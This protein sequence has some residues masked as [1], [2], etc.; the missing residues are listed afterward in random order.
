LE[1]A[2][3]VRI[4]PGQL[5]VPMIR[6]S[7]RSGFRPGACRLLLLF[8]A[9]PLLVP[10]R[11][12]VAQ[13]RPGSVSGAARLPQDST[14]LLKVGRDA[15]R[16]FENLHR[17]RL[18][19]TRDDGGGSCDERL[20]RICL[21]WTGGMAWAP[22][23]EDPV[24]VAARNELLETLAGIAREIPGDRW[25]LG[26]R[27]RYLGDVG[28]WEEALSIADDC[29]GG[30]P[31]WCPAL[32]GYLL[33]RSG[34]AHEAAEAFHLALERMGGRQAAKWWDPSV[35]LEYPAARWIR[36]PDGVSAAQ[37]LERF[38]RFADPLFLTPGNERLSEHFSRLFG[39]SLYSDATITLGLS[40]GESLEELLVRY[41][42]TAGWERTWPGMNEVGSGS[43]VEHHHP[44]SRGLLPPLEALED[45][46]G[47]PRGV[48]VPK[49]DRPR[50]ASAPVLAPLVVEGRGQ[51]A[52]LRRDGD[53]LVVAAYATPADTL[54]RQRRDPL[55]NGSDGGSAGPPA[56]PWE[57]PGAGASRDTLAGLF[58]LADTGAWAPLGTF[59]SGG[60]GTLQ[61]RAPAG[62]YLLSL[63]QWNPSGRWASR[64]RHGIRADVV[65]VDVPTLSDLLLLRPGRSLPEELSQA[66]PRLKPEAYLL[67]GEPVTVGWEVYGLGRRR[68]PLTFRLS[69]LEEK[70]SLVRRA[71]KRIGLFNK[72]P[73]V[74]L[75][76]DEAGSDQMGPLFRA[77]DLALPALDPGRYVLSLEMEI[78]NRGKVLAHRRITIY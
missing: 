38:W 32:R 66:L 9:L 37:A 20:G 43:V 3:V 64:I 5:I 72:P 15:Q 68:E 16:H 58:L 11:S 33:H 6:G 44:E 59:S 69:L 19:R 75:S 53:L 23:P 74:T 28:R 76:W 63:E 61:L 40:W 45:P 39:A 34:R 7:S 35:L 73:A 1:P 47:L 12:G 48:W 13:T 77:V 41:G 54:L 50:S 65:P 78:P 49:D 62:G 71:F 22:E 67:S 21:R 18:P 55:A 4:H 27:I 56:A 14:R 17:S 36:E 8:L 52:V 26:Q 29:A 24:V 60:E 70:G 46:A 30:E 42:F 2:V 57:L 25:I 31:W 10:F 51:T